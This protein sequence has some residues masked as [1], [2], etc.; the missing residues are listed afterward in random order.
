MT[1]HTDSRIIPAPLEDVFG[2]VADVERYPDFLPLWREAV[3]VRR[4]DGGYETKQVIGLGP[5][6][7][8]FNSRTLLLPPN[9]I[10]VSSDDALFRI[11]Y[12]RWDFAVVPRGCRIGIALQ[13]EVQSPRLQ[14][15]ISILLPGVARSMVDAFERRA[16]RGGPLQVQ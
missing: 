4:W 2:L 5:I 10:E 7:E 16:G 8:R 1:I 3:I 11:F 13:W 9:R 15:A 12:I 14:R 6:R